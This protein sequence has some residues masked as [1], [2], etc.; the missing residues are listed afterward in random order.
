MV[1]IV[2]DS[3]GDIPSDLVQSL[4]IVV[5]PCQVFWGDRSYRDGIDLLPD[6]F[7]ERLRRSSEIP[8]TSQP[9][10]GLFEET[11]RK[12]LREEGADALVSIHVAA[13]LSGTLNAAWAAVQALPEPSRVTVVDSGQLSMGMGWAVVEAARMAQAGATQRVL[14]ESV[15]QLLPRLRT[16]AMIDT[17]ENLVHGGRINVISAALASMLDIKPLLS[18]RNGEVAVWGRSRTR[19]RAL[20]NLES[21]VRGWGTVSEVAILHTGAEEMALDLAHKLADW[22]P[23]GHV[24]VAAAGAG[25]TSHL[26]LGAIGICALL[27]PD[28]GSSSQG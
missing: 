26:G 22:A 16:A 13:S 11:Y 17:L 1:R 21:R 19:A 27:A 5:V 14:A 28:S 2:T 4:R 9:S 8:R 12:L 24:L 20:K 25:L 3:T 15:H 23:G 7:H 6:E 18:V 10:V